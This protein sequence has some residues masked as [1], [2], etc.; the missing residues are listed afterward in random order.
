MGG[1]VLSHIV[2]LQGL[3]YFYL[4]EAMGVL[5]IYSNRKVTLMLIQTKSELYLRLTK[6]NSGYELPCTYTLFQVSSSDNLKK[7]TCTQKYLKKYTCT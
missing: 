6:L 7:C 4:F 3:K 1:G 2:W 5:V